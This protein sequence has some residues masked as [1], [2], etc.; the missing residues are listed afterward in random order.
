MNFKLLSSIDVD[1]TQSWGQS[2]FLT[3]DIDWA[4]D[5][6]LND[7]ID[8]LESSRI[9]ATWFATHDTKVLERLRVNQI[10]EMGYI[11]TTIHYWTDILV[12]IKMQKRFWKNFRHCSSG[13][14]IEVSLNDTKLPITRFIC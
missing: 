2:I 6:V 10:F 8:L 1:R 3:L 7:T 14:I 5:E 4:H 13:E 9:K 12:K 11:Q